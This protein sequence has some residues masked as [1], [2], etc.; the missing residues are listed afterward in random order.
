MYFISLFKWKKA[1]TR[2][3]IEEMNWSAQREKLEKQGIKVK[4]F[5]TFGRYDA[6]HI[7]EAPSEN[8]AMKL[9]LQFQDIAE[10]ETL[11]AVPR[12]EAIKLL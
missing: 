7:I 4:S 9:L 1:P 11:A 5:W 10:S 3:S 2:E 8:E 6:I 12:E